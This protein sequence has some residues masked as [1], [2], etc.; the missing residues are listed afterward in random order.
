MLTNLFDA[1]DTICVAVLCSAP[2]NIIQ[3]YKQ[4]IGPHKRQLRSRHVSKGLKS[5]YN[6]PFTI[7]I[8]SYSHRHCCKCQNLPLG[9]CY[10]DDKS[11]LHPDRNWRAGFAEVRDE[12]E[13][14]LVAD[15]S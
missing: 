7:S 10:G 14:V 1:R 13:A 8:L 9:R 3:V 2:L 12:G 6:W 5:D 15:C 11:S 4:R